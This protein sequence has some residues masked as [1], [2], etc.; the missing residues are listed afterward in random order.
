[1]WRI[2]GTREALASLQ[3]CGCPEAIS[4][5]NER[6]QLKAAVGSMERRPSSTRWRRNEACRRPAAHG[7]SGFPCRLIHPPSSAAQAGHIAIAAN[8]RAV[9]I[10]AANATG[11]LPPNVDMDE[12]NLQCAIISIS[13]RRRFESGATPTEACKATFA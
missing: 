7:S 8:Q 3:R 1:M 2:G 13:N 6:W 10:S 11:C 12:H 5:E 4:A 9:L